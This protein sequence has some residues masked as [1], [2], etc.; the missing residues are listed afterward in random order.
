MSNAAD[1]SNKKNL[2]LTIGFSVMG[3]RWPFEKSCFFGTV[4]MKVSLAWLQE[5]KEEN[6]KQ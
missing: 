4:R 5:I 6:W 3:H 1:R 2:E